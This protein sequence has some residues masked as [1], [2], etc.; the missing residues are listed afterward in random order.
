MLQALASHNASQIAQVAALGLRTIKGTLY[1]EILQRLVRQKEESLP[2]TALSANPGVPGEIGNGAEGWKLTAAP[3]IP[4]AETDLENPV[5]D[6][7]K[8]ERSSGHISS[9]D[10]SVLAIGVEKR[11]RDKDHLRAVA[12]MPC[13]VCNRQPAHAHHLKFAQRR[14]T[15]QKVSDEYV[16]PLCALHHG[17]LHRA[18]REEAWWQQHDIDPLPIALDLW[19]RRTALQE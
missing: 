17:D 5:D 18:S 8:P 12:Q 4:D 14:G 2:P 3:V 11:I 6:T 9:I 10:K 13:L 15:S 19:T 7:D 1:S 16:V